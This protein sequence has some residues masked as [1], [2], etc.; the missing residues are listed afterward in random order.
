MN[1]KEF[2]EFLKQNPEEAMRIVVKAFK[3]KELLK[4]G[5]RSYVNAFKNPE[6][7]F[8]IKDL[9]PNGGSLQVLKS[10]MLQPLRDPLRLFTDQVVI[11]PSYLIFKDDAGNIYA[12]NGRTG[13]INF[14]GTDAATVIQ[15]A[16]DALV[17]KGGRIFIQ[18]GTYNITR[19]IKLIPNLVIEGES[20]G[21]MKVDVSDASVYPQQALGVT[22]NITDTGVS[23]VFY[24]YDNNYWIRNVEISKVAVRGGGS[25]S[26]GIRE[27]SGVVTT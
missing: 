4:I 25:S 13:Q 15:Q 2:E 26:L 22:L 24:Y 14:P 10:D 8:D 27:R 20:P 19:S 23:H 9:M 11:P 16:I 6:S 3:E 21:F 18:S 7:Y 5:N 1:K 17:G 12:K